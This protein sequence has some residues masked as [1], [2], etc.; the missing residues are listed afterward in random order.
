[1]SGSLASLLG[2]PQ[3]ERLGWTLLHFLWEGVVIAKLFSEARALAGR[4]LDARGRYLLA[5][6]TLAAMMIAPIVTFALIS[7]GSPEIPANPAGWAARPF[8]VAGSQIAGAEW[9]LAFPS[10]SQQ[11][12]PWLVALWLCGVAFFTA[13]LA[14]GWAVASRLRSPRSSRLAPPEWQQ[15]LER[16]IGR[17]GVSRPVQL[18]ASSIAQTPAAI[19]YWKPVILMPA[20]VLANLPVEQVE[21]LLAHELAHIARNDYLINLLQSAAEALLFYHPSVWWLSNEIRAEREHCCDDIAV[22][23]SGDVLVYARALAAVESERP[24]RLQ[25]AMAAS[26]GSLVN[27]IRRLL[28][29]SQ[30]VTQMRPGPGA[31]AALAVVLAAGIAAAAMNREAPTMQIARAVA[32]ETKPVSGAPVTEGRVDGRPELPR[33]EPNWARLAVRPVQEPGRHEPGGREPDRK[34]ESSTGRAN[35]EGLEYVIL[36][37]K[38]EDGEPRTTGLYT[39]RGG[40]SDQDSEFHVH[41]PERSE[42]NPE[43]GVR[44]FER[45]GV[46]RGYWGWAAREPVLNR[47]EFRGVTED[48]ARDLLSRLPVR[49][50]LRISGSAREKMFQFSRE[51]GRQLEFSLAEDRDGGAVLRIH[52]PGLANAELLHLEA[53]Q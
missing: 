33:P 12:L 38:N 36:T 51:Y 30:P 45:A 10:I 3:V 40:E 8:A 5:C 25:A 21:A 16:L 41:S 7:S 6:A 23:V 11:V 14:G 48:L 1:M 9:Q 43:E 2:Q 39:S 29:G 26:G 28:R 15:R 4:A 42:G 18:L 37:N 35:F 22:A 50:G 32:P 46:P 27:R 20:A 17:V 31:A 47:I 19:G 34:S 13:R 52:P 53:R 24:A 49:E 44:R